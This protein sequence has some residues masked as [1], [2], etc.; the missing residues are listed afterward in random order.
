MDYPGAAPAMEP[1]QAPGFLVAPPLLL[2][3]R[4][5]IADHCSARTGTQAI[6]NIW[7]SS[8]A[9]C[10]TNPYSCQRL[11]SREDLQTL[12][13]CSGGEANGR[14]M[15]RDATSTSSLG[16]QFGEFLITATEASLVQRY[17]E[18]Y[19]MKNLLSTQTE[20]LTILMVIAAP[21]FRGRVSTIVVD[22]D[23]GS[24]VNADY[25]IR[26]FRAVDP[27]SAFLAAYVAMVAI[28][29]LLSALLLGDALCRAWVA[30]AKRWRRRRRPPV[31]KVV[32]FDILLAI[33]IIASFAQL[34]EER[35]SASES[36]SKHLAVLMNEAR[37]DTSLPIE[38]K[39]LQFVE[40]TRGIFDEISTQETHRLVAMCVSGAVLLRL[41]V[42]TQAHPRIAI[43][44]DTLTLGAD[45]L[46]HYLI[47]L[48]LIF[49]SFVSMGLL[50]FGGE[51][52]EF[53]SVQST[54][55]LLG[56][57]M[58]TAE[59][60]EN[61]FQGK[62][63]YVLFIICFIVIFFF[64]MLN[65]LLAIIVDMYSKVQDALD[66]LKTEQD[67]VVDIWACVEAWFWSW[68]FGWPKAKV[69]VQTLE[70]QSATRTVTA[71]SLANVCDRWDAESRFAFVRFYRPY[72]FLAPTPLEYDY[73][74]EIAKRVEERIAV[75]I[76]RALPPEVDHALA[77]EAR[78]V[79]HTRSIRSKGSSSATVSAYSS[80]RTSLT[81]SRH[82]RRASQEGSGSK[83]LSGSLTSSSMTRW[84][85]TSTTTGRGS[86]SLTLAG[87]SDV[88]PY[89]L[90]AERDKF[91][92]V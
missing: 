62:T 12:V 28:I 87:A 17:G 14:F 44:V 45:S 68:Y 79:Q 11:S 18:T 39:F 78:R 48:I 49:S 72:E 60:P 10:A 46:M 26:H 27:G 76:G 21:S 69:I 58:M 75:L 36:L 24:T 35:L 40:D 19:E 70:A 37:W 53:G 67:V 25:Q 38:L 84:S 65:F 88:F 66:Q 32:Y 23:I 80:M 2:Q 52:K 8:Q 90:A 77:M 3:R 41:I 5:V 42:A 59:M 64:L 91:T 16:H 61:T 92:F 29:F 9:Q 43:L 20:H 6:K 47:L 50:F 31:R 73:S 85:Q 1:F 4:K 86:S 33:A 71:E 51:R 15:G 34:L 22:V 89:E 7:S 13:A 55:E 57:L 56:S 82:S 54:I 30:M 81:G 74:M 63:G 83:R